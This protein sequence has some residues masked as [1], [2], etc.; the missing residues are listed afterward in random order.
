MEAKEGRGTW[1][2]S[3]LSVWDGN[4][5]EATQ[6]PNA[7]ACWINIILNLEFSIVRGKRRDNSR[8]DIYD[9]FRTFVTATA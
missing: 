3:G 5:V 1:K 9:Q 2:A 4:N 6:S 7:R 8:C